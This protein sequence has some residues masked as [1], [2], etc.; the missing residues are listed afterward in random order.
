MAESENINKKVTIDVA[1]TS[2]VQGAISPLTKLGSLVG[3][4]DLSIKSLMDSSEKMSK[5]LLSGAVAFGK[6]GSSITD[7]K[8]K[9][10]SLSKQLSLTRSDVAA[11]LL[12]YEKTSNFAS[13]QSAE[14]RFKNISEAVGNNIDAIKEMDSALAGMQDNWLG[15]ENAISGANGVNK[16][17]LQSLLQ[18]GQLSVQQIKIAQ[19]AIVGKKQLTQEAIKEEERNRKNLETLEKMRTTFQDIAI[20]VGDHFLP[21][22]LKLQGPLEKIGDLLSSYPKIIVAATTAFLLFKGAVSTLKTINIIEEGFGLDKGSVAKGGFKLAKKGLGKLVSRT[23]ATTVATG[24][25]E[26]I[27]LVGEAAAPAAAAGVTAGSTGL[28]SGLVGTVTSVALPLLATYAFAKTAAFAM[29]KGTDYAKG[30]DRDDNGN[31]IYTRLNS[32]IKRGPTSAEIRAKKEAEEQDIKNKQIQ[33]DTEEAIFKTNY[34]QQL[35]NKQNVSAASQASTLSQ[36]SLL[37]ITGNTS[38]LNSGIGSGLQDMRVVQNSAAKIAEFNRK[39]YGEGTQVGGVGPNQSLSQIQSALEKSTDPGEKNK[40]LA[41]EQTLLNF[42][43]EELKAQDQMN[44]S[45]QEQVGFIK[46][47]VEAQFKFKTEQAATNTSLAQARADLANSMGAGLKASVEQQLNIVESLGKE[48]QLSA[49]KIKSLQDKLANTTT[50]SQ[51]LELN[52]AIT[53]EQ[54]KQLHTQKAQAE[55]AKSIRDGYVNAIAAMNTGTGIF[56]K[57]MIDNKSNLGIG[58]Q[59][60]N[61]LRSKSSGG[62]YGGK[63][64][65]GQFT[66]SGMDFGS[67]EEGYGTYNGLNSNQ[68]GGIQDLIQGVNRASGGQTL[69]G[70]RL[71]STI[72]G[73]P[74][75]VSIDKSSIYLDQQSINAVAHAVKETLVKGINSALAKGPA[76]T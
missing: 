56:K 67:D 1:V 69:V 3:A 31:P 35:G 25:I 14:N 63:T 28:L 50:E 52:K 47:A 2:A 49:E 7:F 76:F 70:G 10:S 19:S 42:K 5:T 44:K 58:V 16:E 43:R 64:R 6:F 37:G 73:K 12:S 54:V 66:T 33:K 65:A 9:L 57:I 38:Q 71:Q 32:D 36:V 51:K 34:T 48:A 75:A 41:A 72:K 55:A 24:A 17:Y 26:T 59:S 39:A 29:E 23:A 53:E 61:V 22:I 8:T 15:I 46:Q 45:S 11:L 68:G 74:V 40:L 20:N 13:L 21:V 18:S 60:L 27:P 30:V 4:T 62:T